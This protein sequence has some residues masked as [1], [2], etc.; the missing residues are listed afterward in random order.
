V[1]DGWK[2]VHHA[3]RLEG[4]DGPEYELFNHVDD[5]LDQHDV[6]AE[7]ADIVEDLKARLTEWHEMVEAGKLPRGDSTEGL[8]SSQ[9]DKLRSLGYIQ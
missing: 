2:L 6:A 1:F 3:A 4:D 5:P 9:L 8:D 7:H